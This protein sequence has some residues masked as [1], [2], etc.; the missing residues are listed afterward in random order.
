MLISDF[1]NLMLY[2]YVCELLLE[3]FEVLLNNNEF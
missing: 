3:T 1:S 2:V